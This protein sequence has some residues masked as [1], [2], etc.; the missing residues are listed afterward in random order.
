MNSPAKKAK[1]IILVLFFLNLSFLFIWQHF[2]TIG[3]GIENEEEILT[4]TSFNEPTFD[5]KFTYIR[6]LENL[7]IPLIAFPLSL[8]IL[9]IIDSTSYLGERRVIS[10]LVSWSEEINQYLITLFLT[11]TNSLEVV[12]T[13]ENEI[14]TI[15]KW[16]VILKREIVYQIGL[17]I[18]VQ[19][20]SLFI[21]KS[22]ENKIGYIHNRDPE[23]LNSHLLVGSDFIE[24]Y[25]KFK[26]EILEIG[27]W[28]SDYFKVI[29]VYEEKTKS[30]LLLWKVTKKS[31]N[32][33]IIDSSPYKNNGIYVTNNNLEYSYWSPCLFGWNEAGREFSKKYVK[34]QT[35]FMVSNL[36]VCKFVDFSNSQIL[37]FQ[38]C[39]KHAA[40]NITFGYS[41]LAIEIV[42]KDGTYLF[43]QTFAL[44]SG[45]HGWSSVKCING[46]YWKPIKSILMILSSI[47][48]PKYSH[49]FF[50]EI[51]L[52][53]STKGMGIVKSPCQNT[54]N[55]INTANFPIHPNRHLKFPNFHLGS[56][57]QEQVEYFSILKANYNFQFLKIRKVSPFVLN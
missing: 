30:A 9:F 7:P 2:V 26:G 5:G 1:K 10:Q 36:E 34:D 18:N 49:S 48:P 17:D 27:L 50:K 4:F 22:L 8:E 14:I 6:T 47:H 24:E 11:E 29:Q 45:T 12:I 38:F 33:Q 39:S 13:E 42:F 3:T 31:K 51:S 43:N 16:D 23:L 15:C 52:Q 40:N 35:A 44:E 41:H 28:N 37:S 19:S 54:K 25:A 20:I 21:N 55:C 56:L 57:K 32:F 53:T 46:I